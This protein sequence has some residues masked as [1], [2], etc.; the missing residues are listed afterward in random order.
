MSMNVR[1]AA[2]ATAALTVILCALSVKPGESAV[3]VSGRTPDATVQVGQFRPFIP[4]T[5]VDV[6]TGQAFYVEMLA[7]ETEPGVGVV[8]FALSTGFTPGPQA[9][10]GLIGFG[11]GVRLSFCSTL[12][13]T[14][15]LGVQNGVL[16]GNQPGAGIRCGETPNQIVRINSHA[17]VC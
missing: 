7:T 9:G 10:D 6:N 5:F 13:P 16:S 17:R 14:A 12:G 3:R 8:S 2:R 15:L 4:A 11:D 1:N